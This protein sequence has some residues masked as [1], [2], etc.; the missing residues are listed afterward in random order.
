MNPNYLL[1]Y[2]K[3]PPDLTGLKQQQSFVLLLNLQFGSDLWGQLVSASVSVGVCVQ[4]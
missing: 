4:G 2:Y 3:Y 1:L